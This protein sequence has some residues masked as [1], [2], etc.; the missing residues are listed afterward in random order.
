MKFTAITIPKYHTPDA[1]TSLLVAH[2]PSALGNFLILIDSTLLICNPFISLFKYAVSLVS[3]LATFGTG[4][5]VVRCIFMWNKDLFFI[6]ND[7]QSSAKASRWLGLLRVS[8]VSS[9]S[10]R[11]TP[12]RAR[13]VRLSSEKETDYWISNPVQTPD[14]VLCF[15]FIAAYRLGVV[16]A[17]IAPIKLSCL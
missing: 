7:R 3:L 1:A 14:H 8:E 5:S 6:C 9:L 12:T 15:G 13:A 10:L 2:H 4:R 11:Y 17:P 16:L